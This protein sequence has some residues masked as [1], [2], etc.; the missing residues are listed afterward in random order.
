LVI[1]DI[2][3]YIKKDEKLKKLLTLMS[4][5]GKKIFLLTNSEFYYSNLVLGYLLNDKEKDWKDYFGN[6]YIN[7]DVI[8]VSACKP[9]FFSDGT[10]CREVDVSNNTL[11]FKKLT[12]FEKGLFLYDY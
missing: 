11:K 5:S 12:T 2:S 7:Q 9:V 3:K 1:S 4:K 10:T 8:I 6:N